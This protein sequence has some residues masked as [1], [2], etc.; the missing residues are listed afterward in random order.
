MEWKVTDVLVFPRSKTCLAVCVSLKSLK[1]VLWYHGDYF[2]N[3]GSVL[4]ID[5]NEYIVNGRQQELDIF[6]IT[7]FMPEQWHQYLKPHGCSGMN[8]STE[9][10]IQVK[11]CAFILCPFGTR[12]YITI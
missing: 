7:P 6:K 10:C 9:K 5:N 12:K 3:T 1:L 4:E 8:K 2:L 11:K